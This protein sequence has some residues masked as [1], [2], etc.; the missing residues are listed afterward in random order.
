MELA[1][2]CDGIIDYPFRKP[3]KQPKQ[4]KLARGV[5]RALFPFS[6]DDDDD[7][8]DD[9]LDPAYGEDEAFANGLL[10]ASQ[11]YQHLALNLS[12]Q[13]SRGSYNRIR[14]CHEFFLAALSWPDR[15]FR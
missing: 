9:F 12:N 10:L 3:N 11:T 5:S 14:K 7:D 13:G 4:C 1:M 8:D 15:D 6:L 2:G